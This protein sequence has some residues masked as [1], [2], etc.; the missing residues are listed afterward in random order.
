MDN[1]LNITS[2]NIDENKIE[3]ELY[4]NHVDYI[5]G[6]YYG[7]KICAIIVDDNKKEEKLNSIINEISNIYLEY[8]YDYYKEL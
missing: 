4:C 3:E 8:N 6:S 1:N 2:N 7:C 5:E